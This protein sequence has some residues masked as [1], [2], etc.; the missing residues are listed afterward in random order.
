MYVLV[1][2]GAHGAWCWEPLLPHLGE[3]ALAVDLPG[4]GPRPADLARVGV[5]DF[6]EAVVEEILARDLRHVVLVGHSLAG[7]TLPRVAA[8]VAGRIARLVFISCV[9]PEPGR[10]VLEA[11][12]ASLPEGVGPDPGSAAGVLPEPVAREMFC[13]DM[14]E[15][16][17]RFV[18]DRLGP[19]ATR[20]LVEPADLGGLASAVPRTYVRLLRDRALAP[21]LQD[22]MLRRLG[23]AAEVVSFDAGHD[24]MISRPGELGELLRA[25]ARAG[26]G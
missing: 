7:I 22:R 18:L 5:A 15:S 3:P 2:G 20:P 16:Q 6:A 13:N 19:E 8:R 25:V 12:G 11:L 21:A 17:A 10:S 14:D 1:H 9:L 24:A 26:V 4:R 23:P